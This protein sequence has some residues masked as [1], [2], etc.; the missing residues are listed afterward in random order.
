MRRGSAPDAQ[1]PL[2]FHYVTEPRRPVVKRNP[3]LIAIVA[4]ACLAA[5]GSAQQATPDRSGFTLLLNIGVGIQ[6]DEFFGVTETGLGGL[7]LGLGGFVDENLALLF[8]TSGTNVSYDG[9]RQTSGTAGA[10]LQY[11]VND[12]VNVEGGVGIGFWN[13]ENGGD[14]TG[15][16]LVLGAAYS[17]WNNERH[18]L[19]VGIEYAPAFTDPETVH[20]FG[21]VFGW[22]LL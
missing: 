16:G 6:R 2:A 17:I 13:F 12:R 22:Q 20:N 1:S 18:S 14:D 5:A 15:L 21:L 19:S 8:R 7:N 9:G 11:W 4:L 10:T 3:M